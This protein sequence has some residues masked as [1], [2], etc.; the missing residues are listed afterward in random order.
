MVSE[1]EFGFLGG[2]QMGT[3]IAKGVVQAEIAPTSQMAFYEPNAVQV[4]K[5]K[6]SLPWPP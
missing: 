4:A 6:E 3:A 5:L 1:I 2:G